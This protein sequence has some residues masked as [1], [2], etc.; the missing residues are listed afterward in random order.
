MTETSRLRIRVFPGYLRTALLL[1]ASAVLLGGMKMTGTIEQRLLYFPDREVS[2]S[3]ANF[4]LEYEE[5]KLTTSDNISLHGWFIPGVKDRPVILFFH[6]NAGNIVHRLD[7]ISLLNRLG[8]NVLIFDYRGFG[9]ST[10]SPSESGLT[11]D[12][13][14]AHAWLT[15]NGWQQEQIIYFG[16]SL[17]A[18]VAINLARQHPPARLILE[19]PFTSVPAMGRQHYPILTTALSWMLRDRFDNLDKIGAIEVPLLVFQGDRD[20]IVPEKMARELFDAAS[21][22][23]TFHLI[24][25]A[26]HNNTYERG[27]EAYWQA[28]R[29]FTEIAP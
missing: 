3:P 10:G 7:N 13:L 4:G 12:A 2:S 17:G 5:L 29:K 25:G 16:R 8:L 27:G 15:A 18:G 11:R 28:W 1:L 9:K 20:T 14:A 26:D 6:G 22:P 21:P 19:T 24:P 23:K